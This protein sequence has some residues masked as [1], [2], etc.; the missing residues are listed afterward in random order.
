[1]SSARGSPANACNARPGTLR[2]PS[3]PPR[4]SG[5]IMGGVSDSRLEVFGRVRGSSAVFSHGVLY[6]SCASPRAFQ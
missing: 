6:S 3:S 5:G 4:G 1:M 2:P